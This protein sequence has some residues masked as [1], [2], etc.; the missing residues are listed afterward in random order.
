MHHSRRDVSAIK[1]AM[2]WVAAKCGREGDVY[3]PTEADMRESTLEEPERMHGVGTSGGGESS[4][5]RR[6]K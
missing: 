2:L 1:K 3:M 4:A 5:Q 6:G